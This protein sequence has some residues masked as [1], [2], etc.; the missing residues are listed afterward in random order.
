MRLKKQ[1]MRTHPL[2]HRIFSISFITA[3]LVTAFHIAA[4]HR[5]T[6]ETCL[7]AL[8]RLPNRQRPTALAHRRPS[9]GGRA[10]PHAPLSTISPW[11]T[12]RMMTKRKTRM[13][14][15]NKKEMRRKISPNQPRGV[16]RNVRRNWQE[17]QRSEKQ[18]PPKQSVPMQPQQRPAEIRKESH[19]QLLHLHRYL[20]QWHQIRIRRGQAPQQQRMVPIVMLP[21]P[22]P[23]QQRR[24]HQREIL[25]QP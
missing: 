5:R 10:T 3:T 20:S 21:Q 16:Q 22:T 2:R 24:I 4:Q 14:K 1:R 18:K 8:N 23:P 25:V 13:K 9:A 12:T 15:M 17:R 11:T 7:L 19:R 6:I